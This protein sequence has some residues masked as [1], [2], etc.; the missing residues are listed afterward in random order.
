MAVWYM[1]SVLSRRSES[2]SALFHHAPHTRTRSMVIGERSVRNMLSNH[3]GDASMMFLRN[4]GK[5]ALVL[6]ISLTAAVQ[7]RAQS[8][9][10]LAEVNASKSG[11]NQA[12]TF[13]EVVKLFKLGFGE[14]DVLKVLAKS[15]T[16]FTLDANQ[17]EELKKAGASEKVLSTMQR[18]PAAAGGRRPKVTDFAIV[19]DCSGSM[20][21]LTRRRTGQDGGRQARALGAD[22]QDAREAQGDF[23]DLWARS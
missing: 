5:L 18:R 19:L 22:C 10:P 15:P 9:A 12:I 13:Q 21:E 23:R 16:I 4:L 8:G 2:N 6:A 3:S 11:A 17:I 14:N 1:L 20:A 7:G